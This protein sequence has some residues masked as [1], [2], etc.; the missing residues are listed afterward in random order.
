MKLITTW[1]T[2]AKKLSNKIIL[3]AGSLPIAWL[4]LPS[5]WQDAIVQWNGGVLALGASGLA[6]AAFISSNIRQNKLRTAMEKAYE[7][8]LDKP[9]E[10]NSG[11]TDY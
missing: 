5:K 10:N 1:R 2:A 9:Y 7:K 11:S 6:A 4:A 3:I 8:V